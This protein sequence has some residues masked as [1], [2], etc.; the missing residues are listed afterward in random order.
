MELTK[1]QSL[2]LFAT[3]VT[4]S[5]HDDY[6][7]IVKLDITPLEAAKVQVKLYESIEEHGEKATEKMLEK[8]LTEGIRALYNEIVNE[9]ALKKTKG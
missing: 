1:E 3:L 6:K 5:Q 9:K 4:L 8:A 7:E 2:S